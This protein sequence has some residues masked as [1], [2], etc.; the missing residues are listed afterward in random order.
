MQSLLVVDLLYELA[1]VSLR[2]FKVLVVLY[3]DLLQ[4]QGSE[5]AFDLGV[6]VGIAS[7]CHADPHSSCFLKPKYILAREAYCTPC[8]LWWIRPTAG[9]RVASAISRAQSVRLVSIHL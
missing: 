7:C 3:V 9:W 8:S 1:Y 2:F 5:E 4:L 6:L